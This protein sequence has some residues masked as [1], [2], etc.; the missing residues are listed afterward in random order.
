VSDQSTIFVVDE[1]PIHREALTSRLSSMGFAPKVFHSAPEYWKAFDPEVSGCVILDVNATVDGTLLQDL[2]VQQPISP[3]V[4]MISASMEVNHV[5]RAMRRGAVD[6][7][8]KRAYSE[9][10]LWESLQRALA[11]DE[12]KRREYAKHRE[13]Q[14]KF[15]SLSEPERQVLRRLLLGENN[16]EIATYLGISR[17]AVEARRIRM[18]KKLGAPNLVAL[19]NY[20]LS[21]KFEEFDARVD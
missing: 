9:L 2:L 1:D 7:L 6:F 17:V 16:R 3:P 18:M 5:V 13:M 10:D 4:V 15:D 11:A 14:R 19:V 21:A 12:L 20:A 8:Q